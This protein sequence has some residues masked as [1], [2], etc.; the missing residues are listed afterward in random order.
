MTDYFEWSDSEESQHRCCP[1]TSKSVQSNDQQQGFNNDDQHQ[2]HSEFIKVNPYD[3]EEFIDY[4]PHPMNEDGNEPHYFVHPDFVS[5][6]DDESIKL[7]FD[8]DLYF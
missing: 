6:W 8:C 3:A 4:V 5:G 1:S 7:N 2:E